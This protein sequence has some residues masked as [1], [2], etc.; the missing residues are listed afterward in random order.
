[1]VLSCVVCV[2]CAVR[3]LLAF[4]MLRVVYIVLCTCCDV[5]L[6][7]VCVCCACVQCAVILCVVL[8]ACVVCCCSNQNSLFLKRQPTSGFSFN[9][10]TKALVKSSEKDA[11]HF[12]GTMTMTS[13][14]I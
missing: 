4:V 12:E 1:M 6:C 14:L 7:V 13:H 5:I 3:G 11:N 8:C 9:S 10:E 2:C